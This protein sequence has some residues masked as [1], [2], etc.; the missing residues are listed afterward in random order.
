MNAEEL[1]I[2]HYIG[3]SEN[4]AQRVLVL[5]KDADVARTQLAA[6]RSSVDHCALIPRKP[7]GK[8]GGKYGL[9]WGPV[10]LDHV[11]GDAEET[12]AFAEQIGDDKGLDSDLTLVEISRTGNALYF[13]SSYLPSASD[14]AVVASELA[15]IEQASRVPLAAMCVFAADPCATAAD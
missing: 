14:D 5:F 3:E 2:V 11:A 10:P 6:L 4:S 9:S 13:D 15:R 1:K 12:F 8:P 7:G